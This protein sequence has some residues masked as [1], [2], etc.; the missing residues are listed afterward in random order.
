MRSIMI[1][2]WQRRRWS[3]YRHPEIGNR[4]SLV[5]SG[6]QTQPLIYLA[7]STGARL[8]RKESAQQDPHQGSQHGGASKPK[9]FRETLQTSNRRNAACIRDEK[10]A[11]AEGLSSDDDHFGTVKRDSSKL[12]PFRSST[13]EQDLQAG[14]WSKSG[15]MET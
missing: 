7:N 15:Q 12:R 6:H 5:R 13:S 8:R 4:A 9:P 2:K 11:A 10:A 3:R 14:V 1:A